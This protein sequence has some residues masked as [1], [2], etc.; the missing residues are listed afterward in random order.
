MEISDKNLTGFETWMISIGRSEDTAATYRAHLERCADTPVL[1]TRVVTRTLSPNTRHL[2][3]A[4]LAAWAR[5]SEDGALAKL[6]KEIRLP[7]AR[8]VAPRV[9]LDMAAWEKLVTAIANSKRLTPAMRAILLV[10]ALRGIRSGD[11]LRLR[12]R[13]LQQALH[14]GTLSY[15]AKGSK[16]LEYAVTP[17]LRDQFQTLLDAEPPYRDGPREWKD[18][19]DLVGPPDMRQKDV[20]QTVRRALSGCAKAARIDQVYPHRLR[21]T[22]AS[23]FIRR[24]Q[25]DPQALVKLTSHMGWANITTAAQ[26]TD[27][28]NREELDQIGADMVGDLL[29]AAKRR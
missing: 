25:N 17:R 7:P 21:R 22:Y 23:H 29:P 10:I 18:V 5:Y 20:S 1:T 6:L 4:A 3:R 14:T 15:E 11:V 2:N 26:Y 28:V 16:R 13:D 27:A 9:E 24:L 8:R 12:R 19:R